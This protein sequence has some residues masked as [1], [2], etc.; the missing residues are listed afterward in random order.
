MLHFDI[1][2]RSNAMIFVILICFMIHFIK[3][4]YELNGSC[5]LFHYITVHI[6]YEE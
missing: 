5:D 4:F 6:K 1:L 3:V 2:L